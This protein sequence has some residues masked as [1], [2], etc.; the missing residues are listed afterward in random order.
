MF[1]AL[2]WER[3]YEACVH[4]R[5]LAVAGMIDGIVLQLISYVW[6]MYEVWMVGYIWYGGDCMYMQGVFLYFELDFVSTNANHDD[7]IVGMV[8][9]G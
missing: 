3:R 1:E 6:C 7:S 8:S 2:Q 4:T 9:I 5:T